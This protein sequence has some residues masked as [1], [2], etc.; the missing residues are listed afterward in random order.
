MMLVLLAVRLVFRW[1]VA[2]MRRKTPA[3]GGGRA[4]TPEL[5]LKNQRASAKARAEEANR[6][7]SDS[8]PT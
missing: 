3:G 5:S 8:S 7:K 2:H 6:L 4:K 1:R